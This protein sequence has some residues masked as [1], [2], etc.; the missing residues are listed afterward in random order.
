MTIGYNK[1]AYR[2]CVTVSKKGLRETCCDVLKSVWAF[3]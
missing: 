2:D 3:D 1:V